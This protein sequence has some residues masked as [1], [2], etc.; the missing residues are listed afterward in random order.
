MV[1]GACVSIYTKNKYLSYDLDFVTY[2][3]IKELVEPLKELGFVKQSGRHFENPSCPY[4][5]EFIAPPIA[6]GDEL[7]SDFNSLKTPFGHLQ[8]L[9]PTD[10][11]KDRLAAYF[12]WDDYQSLEQAVMIAQSRKI[13]LFEVERWAKKENQ[14]KKYNEFIRKLQ[15]K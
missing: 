5:I 3:S 15:I 7:I 13:N 2:S 6:I 12:H 8:L 11:V 1:G 14:L 10:S 4:L 9:T